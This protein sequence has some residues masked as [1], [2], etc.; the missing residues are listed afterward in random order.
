VSEYQFDLSGGSPPI[1]FAN[2]MGGKHRREERLGGYADLIAFARQS[3][4]LSDAL[5]GRLSEA[6]AARP[7]EADA[8]LAR[9]RELREALFALFSEAERPAA[10]LDGLN[11]ELAVAMAQLRVDRALAWTW[12]ESAER[13]DS[14][15]WPIARQAA[16]LLVT[17]ERRRVR[18]CAADDCRW[19]FLD[20]SK[21]KSRRWCDMKS[22]G[23]RAKVR[24]FY[25]RQRAGA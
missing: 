23:N 2:T 21:N 18:E 15:L 3:G 24:N 17:E 4:L 8:V 14:P 12:A 5:A 10:A 22:C 19:L 11:R 9:A 20:T 1:D 25:E 7:A 13:L 6:A 16:E